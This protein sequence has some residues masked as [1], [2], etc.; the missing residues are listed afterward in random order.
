MF[1]KSWWQRLFSKGPGQ[2]ARRQQPSLSTRLMEV[3]VLEDRWMPTVTTVNILVGSVSHSVF[4]PNFSDGSG[5]GALTAFGAYKVA[6]NLRSAV[7]DAMAI[8]AENPNTNANLL[9]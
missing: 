4:T 1:S 7:N 5:G 3:E 9:L 6:P 2:T 8:L